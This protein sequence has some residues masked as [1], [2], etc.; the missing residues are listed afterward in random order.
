MTP[1]E[2]AE[3]LRVEEHLVYQG[4]GTIAAALFDLGRYPGA[5]PHPD[6]LVRGEVHATSRPAIVLRVLDEL[7]GY[8]PADPDSSLYTR[9]STAVTLDD[10]PVVDAFVYFYNVPLGR[11]ERIVSGDYLA[12]LAARAGGRR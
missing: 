2:R 11:A 12:Y 6:R 1:F 10:G 4:Q 5:I 8:Q 3:R 7:E 9:Q